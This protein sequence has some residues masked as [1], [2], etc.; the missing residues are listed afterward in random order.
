MPGSPLAVVVAFI[1]PFQL[2]AVVNALRG[3]PDFPGMSVCE[4]R[5]F[6][7]HAA[8]PPRSGEASEVDPFKK[9]MRIEV[10]CVETQVDSIV[11]AIRSA[12]HTGNP[13]DG[14]V[15]SYPLIGACRIRTGE[16][17]EAALRCG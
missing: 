12:A 11:E 5:G 8:H 9:K 17:G 15:F 1:Q 14:K 3:V 6:G 7:A 4:V 16:K 13:G 10:C 2:E